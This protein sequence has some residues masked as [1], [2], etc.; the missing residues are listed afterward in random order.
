PLR[1]AQATAIFLSAATAG[2]NLSVS[3]FTIPR[4]LESP[5]PLMLRQWARLYASGKATMPAFAGAASLAYFF[6]AYHSQRV[7]SSSSKLY[8]LAGAASV[9]IVPY[10][11]AL[12]ERTN[13]RLL[14]KTADA[15]GMR[16]SEE[17]VEV[18]PREEGAKYLVDRWA[19]LN[20]GRAAL[21]AVAAGVGLYVVLGGFELR[22]GG[23]M[24]RLI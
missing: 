2:A 10:T 5:T 6:L 11:L 22:G 18:G 21:S 16:M 4:L 1:L 23:L 8:L 3:F 15:Q 9:G 20:L 19:T 14:K 24:L 17:L 12:M 7:A 13:R